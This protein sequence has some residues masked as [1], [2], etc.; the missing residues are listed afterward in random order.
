MPNNSPIS[1]PFRTAPYHSGS[2]EMVWP[3]RMDFERC[4]L[5]LN[6]AGSAVTIADGVQ[7]AVRRDNAI[8]LMY[9]DRLLISE[10]DW[11]RLTDEP[12]ARVSCHVRM[13]DWRL[14]CVLSAVR[15]DAALRS[16]E[17]PPEWPRE[18]ALIGAEC[19]ALSFR[20]QLFSTQGAWWPRVKEIITSWEQ[21]ENAPQ[22]QS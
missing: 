20:G 21:G 2:V 18:R 6:V 3:P 9:A 1:V 7:M 8:G 19:V 15:I 5:R 17:L 11:R 12:D 13:P 10:H 14:V 16:L 4:V 22:Q